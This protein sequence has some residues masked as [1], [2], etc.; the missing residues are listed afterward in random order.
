[1]ADKVPP[2]LPE[3][4]AQS[5]DRLR[6]AGR[7]ELQQSGVDA[8]QAL[9]HVGE[10][11]VDTGNAAA[12]ARDASLDGARAAGHA[13]QGAAL[14]AAGTLVAAAEGIGDLLGAALQHLGRALIQV[15][16]FLSRIGG[17]PQ[18][19]VSDLAR[20]DGDPPLSDK[21]M[22]RSQAHFDMAA[23]AL[24][25]ALA[26]LVQSGGN[27]KSAAKKLLKAAEHMADAAAH[28]GSG[29]AMLAAAAAVDAAR[30]AL[31]AAKQGLDTSGALL[32]EAGKRLVE[33][34]NALNS[35]RGT[36]TLLTES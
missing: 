35:P 34:G 7:A 33:S 36:D 1:M 27:M 6:E 17:G 28:A 21:L 3:R 20:E 9:E 12:R 19:V 25:A 10:A 24:S 14:A 18:T 16:N 29:S 13:L 2:K 4:M 23:K 30:L 11:L 8:R 31:E 22:A 26:D 5:A 15:G 32:Q